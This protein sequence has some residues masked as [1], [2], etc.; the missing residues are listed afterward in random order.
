MPEALPNI[1]SVLA[2]LGKRLAEAL[3]LLERIATLSHCR[4]KTIPMRNQALM[5]DIDLHIACRNML[6]GRRCG[7]GTE[8]PGAYQLA[9]QAASTASAINLSRRNAS[10]RFSGCVSRSSRLGGVTS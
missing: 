2:P 7:G 9:D 4:A 1:P 3:A 10:K 6:C 8:Q 5:D